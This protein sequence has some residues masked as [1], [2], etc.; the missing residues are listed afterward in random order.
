VEKQ[1]TTSPPASDGKKEGTEDGKPVSTQ[2]NGQA[3]DKA[4]LAVKT[5]RLYLL[6][7]VEVSTTTPEE[8]ETLNK[9]VSAF[10]SK[11]RERAGGS[12]T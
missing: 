1:E 12:S 7:M 10:L 11:Q 2:P 4:E 8:L 9:S 3:A 5:A 6:A